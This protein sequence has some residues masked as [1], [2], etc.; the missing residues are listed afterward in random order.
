MD[1]ARAFERLNHPVYF[2]FIKLHGVG[3][4]R[5]VVQPLLG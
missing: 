5:Y 2:H 1:L 3:F 4:W